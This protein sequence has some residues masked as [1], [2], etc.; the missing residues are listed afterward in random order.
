M[1]KNYLKVAL[2]TLKRSPGYTFINISSLA[3]GLASCVLIL[4]FIYDELR[5]DRH[6]EHADQV[7]RVTVSYTEG[8]HWAA[9]GPPVG[10]AMQQTIPEVE[11]SARF[12]PYGGN[13]NIFTFEDRQFVERNG[14]MADSTIFQVFTLPLLRGNEHTALAAP[15]TVVISASMAQRYFGN[16]DPLGQ[17]LEVDD[18][19]TLRVTGVMEDVPVTTHAPFD[20]MVSMSTFYSFFDESPDNNI[21]WAGMYTY[22]K[23]RD[24]VD[25]STIEAKLPGF[26]ET[27]Y[28]DVFDE[29]AVTQA[30][31][32]LQPLTSIYLRSAL[33]KEYRANSNI[34]YVYVFGVVAIFI[35]LIACVNFTNLTTA[36]AGNRMREVGIRKTLGSM[37]QQLTIQFLGESLLL[38]AL[39]LLLAYALVW[40]FLPIMN[41]ITG[42]ALAIE[43]SF[44]LVLWSGLICITIFSGLISGFYPAL[45]VSRFTPLNALKGASVPGKERL[46][47]RKG[48]VIFQFA[49]SIFLIASTFIVSEQLSF[50]RGSELGFDK[51]RV[52]VFQPSGDLQD[53]VYEGR[54]IAFKELLKNHSAIEQVSFT[55][56]VPGRRY[57]IENFTI[58]ERPD[59]E[60]VSMRIAWTA[61]H[62]YIKALGVDLVQGRDFSEEAPRD[63]SAWL[64]NEAAARAFDLDDPVGKTI[65]WASMNY[66]GP[67]VGVVANFNF[68][69]L[70]NSVE[71]LVIPLR[72]YRGGNLIVRVQAG[73]LQEALEH[74]DTVVASVAPGTPMNY[75]FLDEE[76]SLLYRSEDQ[77]GQVFKYF[78]FIAILIAC[79]GLIGLAAYTAERRAKEIGVRKVLGATVASVL[80]LLC[81]DFARLVGIAFILA[82]PLSYFMMDRWLQSFAYQISPG[83][84]VFLATGSL[85]LLIAIVTIGYQALQA[86]LSNPVDAL[87]YE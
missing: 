66:A 76:F 33:E 1:L 73:R 17:L 59:V 13:N 34:I 57:S 6:H 22:I 72:P 46:F 38:S 85:V 58:D 60:E 75:T 69:S 52:L 29:P 50:F 71:P 77:L 56:S 35:L 81:K 55:S 68:A 16:E 64:I 51:E 43:G 47:L 67:I 84:T 78:S 41:G 30:S 14:V 49:I 18:G 40:L 28:R 79:L 15:Y 63:T 70:H 25:R 62:E 65:N 87:K 5:H 27:F 23:A 74:I 11:V 82:A 20:F 36:R 2:R 8:S 54:V 7:Y 24:G 4:L 61:D 53:Y 83:V 39:A 31:I 37:R 10:A 21:T 86:A 42:K 3:I 80:V 26:V 44:S 12:R 32:Y 9:I 45:H 48:L 19:Y